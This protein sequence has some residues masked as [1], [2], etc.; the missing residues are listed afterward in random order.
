ML[1]VLVARPD[2]PQRAML[3]EIRALGTDLVRHLRES[4]EE[5]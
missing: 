5:F 1:E 2:W 4:E 3:E